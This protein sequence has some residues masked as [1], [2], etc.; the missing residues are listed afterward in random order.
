MNVRPMTIQIGEMVDYMQHEPFDTV[1]DPSLPTE[2]IKEEVRSGYE[3]WLSDS[4]APT[5]LRAAQVVVVKN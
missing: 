2:A 3:Y 4:Q 1:Q 5:V